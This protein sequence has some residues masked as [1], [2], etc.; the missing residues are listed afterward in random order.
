[1]PQINV[2]SLDGGGVRGII[3]SRLLELFCNLAGI[4]ADKVYQYFNI[5]AGTSIGGIQALG[6]AKG[7]TPTYVKG[8]LIDNAATIFNCTYPI[9]GGGQASYGTWTGYLAGIYSSLYSQTPLAN[10]INSNFGT[11][12]INNYQTNVLVPAFQRSN[13]NGTTNVPIYFSNIPSSIVPYF[14]GQTE[15]SANVAL[16]TSA[17]PVYFPPA[18]FNGCTYV[19]GGIFLNNPAALALAAQKAV[20]PAI[21]KFCVL[22]IGTG[23][24][25]IGYIPGEPTLRGPIDNLN[26]IKMVM[27]VSTAIPP[28]GVAVE[29]N[30]LSNYALE[31]LYY[32]RMQ[33][34]IDLSQEPDSSLDNSDPAFIQYM[35]DSATQYFSDNIESITNFIGHMFS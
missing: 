7:L 19:D 8:L 12:T 30:I 17:A 5:I 32:L 20:Q 4:P 25:S 22:S 2:L 15:L 23:L 26:T 18:V 6:Y 10:L 21:N 27:D 9:P 16:A 35:Q 34:Q 11:D 33:Y 13:A 29:Q 14:S 3:T 28:E 24:G 1:M 31:N